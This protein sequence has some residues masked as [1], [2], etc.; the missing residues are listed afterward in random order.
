MTMTTTAP[1]IDTNKRVARRLADEVFSRGD[2]R[3]FDE[4]IADGY[5]N[6][7]MPVPNVPGTKAGFREI[8]VATRKAFPDVHVDVKDVVAEG[9]FVVF[10]DTV[11][12]TSRG[13]FFG[14]PANGKRLTWTEIHFLR[15][16][17]GRIVEHWTN[18]DQLGILRQ[19]GVIPG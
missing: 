15:I 2:M 4:I 3:A 19:L 7:N 9:N 13:D 17:N 16:A 10:R 14:V 6:H 11:S 5:V 1:E 8:V 12:A 18:F